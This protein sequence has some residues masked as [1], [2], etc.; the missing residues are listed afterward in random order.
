[1][2]FFRA[3]CI[4]RS[5]PATRE[6][7][8]GR[9][10]S[11]DET[12]LDAGDVL[13][14]VEC[15]S[16]NFKD[17]L[18]AT[19]S[20]KVVRRFPCVGGIDLAGTVLRSAAPRFAPGEKVI[21][22]GYELGVAHHGGYAERALLPG[23]WLLPLPASLSSQESMAI[24]TAGLT[25]AMAITRMEENGLK[26]E[27]GPVLVT[28]A[29]GGVGSLA[30][31][32]LAGRGYEVVAL[33]AKAE[34]AEWLRSLGAS[35][36]MLRSELPLDAFKPLD[37]GIWAGV[38]DNLGGATLAWALST[39]KPTGVVA[40]IGLAADSHL[41]ASMMPFV[42][43]GVSLLGID[44]VYA[45]FSVRERAWARLAADLRPRHL[46]SIMRIIPFEAL[47]QVF[48]EFIAA[49]ATGRTVVQ[50]ARSG[51]TEDMT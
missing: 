8:C 36:V 23:G 40:G 2:T 37:K 26:P 11:L 45:G 29:S 24:G 6:A 30:I 19:G 32:M 15:S 44:S 17:A 14:R 25:A 46:A 9:F 28:G 20:G 34:Q 35:R 27:R 21:A 38:I 39:S 12:A 33:T 3:F 13:I 1:M 22:T 5:A 42:L 4:E 41:S 7:L 49:R 48:G 43:R 47:P 51:E 31:D 18:A 50:I 10:L 16:V